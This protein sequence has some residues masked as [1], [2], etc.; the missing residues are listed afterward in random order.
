MTTETKTEDKNEQGEHYEGTEIKGGLSIYDQFA[1]ELEARAESIASMLPSTV[2]PARFK[3]TVIAAIRQ[4]PSIL[5]ATIR[6]VMGAVIRA[7]QDGL[8]PDGREGHIA[9]YN[10]NVAKRG[11]KERW[12][13]RA[14]W[15]PMA[16]GL[17]K[18][19][20]ELDG[21]IANAEVV[22]EKDHFLWDQG[23]EPRIEHRPAPLGSG[24]GKMI[25][26]Y[27]IYRKGDDILHR[28]VM[29]FTQIETTR[30]QSKQPDSLMWKKFPEE[31]YRKVV[32]RRGIK[33]VPVT[34]QMREIVLRDDADNFE[35]ERRAEAAALIP[36]SP[37]TPPPPPAITKQDTAV[38]PAEQPKDPVP[39]N[40]SRQRKKGEN[41]GEPPPV[42]E[43]APP[44]AADAPPFVET[45]DSADELPGGWPSYLDMMVAE[46]RGAKDASDQHAVHETVADA[47]QGDL[48]K[49]KITNSQE[50]L[51]KHAWEVRSAEAGR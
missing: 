32:L 34:D 48:E 33:T 49:G 9:I 51:I 26:A 18:R 8:V 2:T 30:A 43:Q 36:P 38:L 23:D 45:T 46:L 15:N 12:E 19:L 6:S 7:A 50:E 4:D 28:E 42:A 31:G 29:D 40:K 39:V 22:H 1:N 37:P 24:R 17:R 3:N 16:G 25:G 21:I 47:I 44:P 41:R 10:T 11:E 20:R 13:K 35:F 27:C 14:Q 5:Q